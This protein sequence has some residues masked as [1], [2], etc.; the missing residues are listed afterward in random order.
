MDSEEEEVIK[1]WLMLGFKY[2]FKYLSS[3][4]EPGL[5]CFVNSGELMML[6]YAAQYC[7][8]GV[9]CRNPGNK[10]FG[11]LCE[12]QVGSQIR[13]RDLQSPGDLPEV[14]GLVPG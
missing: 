2:L 1:P 5:Y 11:T 3:L 12:V 13:G 14:G 9:Y 6:M 8:Q 10:E 4:F 7:W